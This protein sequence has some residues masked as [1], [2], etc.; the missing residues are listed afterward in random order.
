MKIIF[1]WNFLSRTT[2]HTCRRTNC[3]L[4]T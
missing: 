4:Y 2:R 1:S 3:T